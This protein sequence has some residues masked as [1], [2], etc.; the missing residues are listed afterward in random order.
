MAKKTTA[1]KKAPAKK[2]VTKKAKATKPKAKKKSKAPKKAKNEDDDDF[3][4][5]GEE[6]VEEDLDDLDDDMLADSDPDEGKRSHN[7]VE[8]MMRDVECAFC[9]GSSS[10]LD[11]KVRDD[12][13]CPSAKA[14]L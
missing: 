3:D 10:R 13:G 14:D 11:C 2:K 9:D 1:K 6:F 7:E 4:E 5:D 12:F 8:N